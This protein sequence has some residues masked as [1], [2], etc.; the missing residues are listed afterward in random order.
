MK[1]TDEVTL[2]FLAAPTDV[3]YSGNVDGGRVLTWIDKAAYAVATAWC[4]RRCVTAY[5]GHVRFARPVR[6]GELVEV[7]ARLIH[8]GRSS[9]HIL[10]TVDSS[11][12]RV[13]EPVR[14]TSCLVI[15]VA[16]DDT[17][18][19]IEV[20]VWTPTTEEDVA[21]QQ[22]AMARID[23]RRDIEA[24]MASQRYTDAGTAPK[25][26][27]RFMAAPTDVNWG[28]NV[29]GGNV[30][31]WIDEAAHLLATTYTG[32]TRNVAVYTGGIR[33]YQ[34][35]HI[36]EVVEVEA[37]LLHTGRTSMHIGVHVRSADPTTM[38]F[39]LTTHCLVLFV[40]LDEAGN[41]VE[42][43]KWVP[44]SEEDVALDHHAVELVHLR[45]VV[46][47]FAVGDAG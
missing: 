37:R 19:P 40:A 46:G 14:T 12:P 13:G 1:V 24:A 30:M 18:R 23:L 9:M 27:L 25:A 28:G 16:L 2:R 26:L 47:R 8:T 6:S 32:T 3:G 15:F 35:L 43:P 44:Q 4:G 21:N 45:A 42:C 10:V 5:V 31:Q 22:S 11:D 38:Q 34:P 20:P 41:A 17:G 36:G 7:N 39:R 29:H 33:F